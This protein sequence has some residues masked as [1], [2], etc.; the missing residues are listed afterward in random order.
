MVCVHVFLISFPWCWRCVWILVI[1]VSRP[2]A[3]IISASHKS[4][5]LCFFQSFN[6]HGTFSFFLTSDECSYVENPY[7]CIDCCTAWNNLVFAWPSCIECF[8]YYVGFRVQ[9]QLAAQFRHPFSAS[10]PWVQSVS[11]KFQPTRTKE[12]LVP[13]LS[14]KVLKCGANAFATT[15]ACLIWCTSHLRNRLWF[16][17]RPNTSHFGFSYP[18]T[19][20]TKP[21]D[22]FNKHLYMSGLLGSEMCVGHGFRQKRKK[23]SHMG[24]GDLWELAECQNV[25]FLLY[26]RNPKNKVVVALILHVHVKDPQTGGCTALSESLIHS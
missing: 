25:I 18:V 14:L 16:R 10:L 15:E 22:C 11:M 17:A 1:P 21:F 2:Y 26:I 3:H 4:V 13:L 7:C 12:F 8:H 9:R 23:R 19:Q 6:S 20:V 5:P 24:R